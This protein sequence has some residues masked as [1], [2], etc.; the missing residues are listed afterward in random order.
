M[1]IIA[2]RLVS[3]S[4]LDA[5]EPMRLGPSLL[6]ATFDIRTYTV[7]VLC[8]HFRIPRLR[9]EHQL[10]EPIRAKLLESIAQKS[11]LWIDHGGQLALPVVQMFK[12]A[13]SHELQK[14][15]LIAMG[16]HWL[17]GPSL[18]HWQILFSYNIPH[19]LVH[20]VKTDHELRSRAISN[21]EQLTLE[22]GGN[23]PGV[24]EPALSL[25]GV[26]RRLIQNDL[27]DTLV[28]GI[29]CG[30]SKASMEVWKHAI[31]AFPNSLQ[32]DT[33]SDDRQIMQDLRRY[34]DATHTGPSAMI[35]LNQLRVNLR[36]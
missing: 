2:D 6:P 34:C 26:L 21:F 23:Q 32:P 19:K 20:I 8:Q 29:V 7:D 14:Q 16:E 27:F 10:Q 36:E 9:S 30:V 1:G 4:I 12:T 28:T 13:E 22:L 11:Q 25:A 15:C 18:L 17:A 24:D 3:L 31:I 33:S 35:L 5:S